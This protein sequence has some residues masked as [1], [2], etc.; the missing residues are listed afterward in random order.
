[1]TNSYQPQA[2]P[3]NTFV[4]PSVVAPSSGVDDLLKILQ[5]VNPGLDKFLDNRIDTAIEA[6]QAEGVELALEASKNDFK[7]YTK[8][9]KKKDGEEAARQLIGGSIFAQRAFEKTKTK[10][11]AG[12]YSNKVTTL[13]QGKTYTIT[14]EDENEINQP[15]TH[16]SPNSPQFQDFLQEVSQI[17]INHLENMN[18]VDRI[19][20]YESQAKAVQT[21]TSHHLKEHNIFKFNRLKQQSVPVLWQSFQSYRNGNTEQALKDINEYVNEN[22]ILGLT[23][24]KQTQFWPSL[25]DSGKSITT[26][27]YAE[28]GNVN[29]A[30]EFIKM[31]G[32]I[33]YG[34]KE[35]QKNGKYRQR[36]LKEHPKFGT[37]MFE[38]SRKLWKAKKEDDERQADQ[39]KAAEEFAIK[40]LILKYGKKSTGEEGKDM[41]ERIIEVFPHRKEFVLERIEIAEADRTPAFKALAGA[42]LSGDYDNNSNQLYIDLAQIR[43]D[44]GEATFTDEDEKNYE[45]V[46]DAMERRRKGDYA[47]F[48]RDIRGVLQR[49]AGELGAED[50]EN[51][52]WG[53]SKIES[54][55]A[56]EFR[57]IQRELPRKFKD[58]IQFTPDPKDPTRMLNRSQLEYETEL[59]RLE[60]SYIKK[61]EDERAKR[62]NKLG[63]E[64]TEK[65]SETIKPNMPGESTKEDNK[66]EKGFFGKLFSSAT[67]GGTS[68]AAAGTLEDNLNIY[69]VKEG[70]NLSAI[71]DA[72][73]I[74]V[75]D[76]LETNNIT[77]ADFLQIG[78]KLI[79]PDP[80]PNF[81]D[82]YKG[83]AIPD[84][85]G[86]AALVRSGESRGHG[87]YNA[88]NKGSTDTAGTMDIT[89][90]TIAEMEKL[91]S[92]GEV[93]AVGAYQLT[94]GVLAEVREYAG[95]E[96][97]AIMT[98]AV[99]DKL[100]SALI[101]SGNKRPV[102]TDYLLGD[103]DD[104]RAAHEAL[105]KEFA[106]LQGPDG[107]G[108]YDKD[109]AGNLATIEADKVKKA[110]IEA[111]QVLSGK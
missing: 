95:I 106:A 16:F 39:E 103:S 94:P 35:K 77:D 72:N 26:Q 109:N 3:V 61:I 97:D 44:I 107:V 87:D 40:G 70:D 45:I 38:Q 98:P 68:P 52:G 85:G 56:K 41:L 20:F 102:L 36:T 88:F 57:R 8:S 78:Q 83:K 23:A 51:L 104:L 81:M 96:A 82:Q 33:Q 90:K 65:G 49:L 13:Y 84:F 62:K 2:R 105:A 21:I 32:D 29:D 10:L 73:K 22:V 100:F 86:L 6:E 30:Q 27:I 31:F 79:I 1:M 58:F 7:N 54:Q 60:D 42:V 91:Q 28:T 47:D 37:L 53:A 75:T 48:N 12:N 92:D 5:S 64:G 76:L 19:T 59:R 71:A 67:P 111:R 17:D 43:R 110:L 14:D 93:Y 4:Q 99:Q 63:A 108:M 55:D 89:S 74:E 69:T 11:L 66:K 15:I 18:P 50:P 101:L 80:K 9:I 34:P 25:L 46:F 24:D